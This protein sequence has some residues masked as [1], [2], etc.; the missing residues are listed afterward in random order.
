MRAWDALRSVRPGINPRRVGA[1]PSG[2]ATDFDSVMRRFESSRPSHM[3]VRIGT[4]STSLGNQERCPPNAED[5]EASMASRPERPDPVSL[6]AKFVP[7]LSAPISQCPG[8]IEAPLLSVVNSSPTP[9]SLYGR[10]YI[11]QPTSPIS[12]EAPRIV[13]TLNLVAAGLGPALVPGSLRR[14]QMDGVAYRA[15]QGLPQPRAPLLA[16]R[17]AGTSAVVRRRQTARTVPH[18][19]SLG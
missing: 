12:Q 13:S 8:R 2:K 18:P 10:C 19:A 9:R 1:S 3:Y 15:L 17:R 14:M 6:A 16:T 11:H 7:R 5:S 4:K